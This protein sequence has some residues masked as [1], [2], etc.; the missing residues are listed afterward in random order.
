MPANEEEGL[1]WYKS[2][3]GATLGSMITPTAQPALNVFATT[4]GSCTFSDLPRNYNLN[5]PSLKLFAFNE[6]TCSFPVETPIEAPS[7]QPPPAQPGVLENIA[8]AIKNLLTPAANQAQAPSNFVGFANLPAPPQWN[9]NLPT[10]FPF[11]GFDFNALQPNSPVLADIQAKITQ[12][13]QNPQWQFQTNFGT[14]D[15][16]MIAGGFFLPLIPIAIG[17]GANIAANI[18]EETAKE[19]KKGKQGSIATGVLSGITKGL[20]AAFGLGEKPKA[21]EYNPI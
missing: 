6:G 19:Q 4:R 11:G 21:E 5:L 10:I 15:W 12:F 2:G 8:N 9:F 17:A 1:K 20:G 3:G 7:A 18:A 13:L 16:R 14:Y